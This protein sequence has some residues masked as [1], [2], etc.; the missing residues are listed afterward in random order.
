MGV[1]LRRAPL[2]SC[3]LIVRSTRPLNVHAGRLCCA[4]HASIT[5]AEKRRPWLSCS[6]KIYK[7]ISSKRKICSFG[8]DVAA[9]SALIKCPLSLY[10]FSDFL[11][12]VKEK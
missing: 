7:Q 5:H 10:Y 4:G 3:S 1:S 6:L 2:A 8:V 12:A 11:L 9:I